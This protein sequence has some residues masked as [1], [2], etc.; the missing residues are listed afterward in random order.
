MPSDSVCFD[1][2]RVG[3]VL[4][5]S[6]PRSPEPHAVVTATG[7]DAEGYRVVR[8]VRANGGADEWRCPRDRALYPPIREGQG[9]TP[10]PEGLRT[11][12]QRAAP[13][14]G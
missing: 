8:L 3:D 11:F 12:L 14:G 13:G 5:Y 1:A 2:L 4:A 9:C 10:T 7:C 6:D